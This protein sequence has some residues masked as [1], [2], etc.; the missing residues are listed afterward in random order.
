[1]SVQLSIL[2]TKS[3]Q[4]ASNMCDMSVCVCLYCNKKKLIEAQST[5]GPYTGEP[6]LI[7]GA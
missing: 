7:G 1:M 4:K 3:Y 5:H 2:L 6:G